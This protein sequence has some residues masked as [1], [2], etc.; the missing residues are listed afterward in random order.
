MQIRYI[1]YV[2]FLFIISSGS[3]AFA[4]ID[5]PMGG[6]AIPKEKSKVNSSPLPAKTDLPSSVMPPAKTYNATDLTKKTEEFSMIKKEEFVNRGSEYQDRVNQSVQQKGESNEAYRGNQSF[7]EIRTKSSYFTIFSADYG[8]EDGDRI[9]VLVND[10]V[11]IPEFT[12]TNN[13][14]AL[15]IML[16][17]GFNKIEFE[18]MN[19]G[20]SG[21]N[22]AQFT[23]IDDHEKQLMSNQWNLATGFKASVMV[24]KE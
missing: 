12:L 22:T 1:K 9:R 8:L 16:K 10:Q 24:I 21:P 15:Q 17:P 5:N 19:Q 6:F 23:V 3:A 13:S 20:T 18:A 2:I 7:G 4:Q 11:V 14:K